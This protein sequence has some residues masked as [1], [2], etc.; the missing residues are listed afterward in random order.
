MHTVSAEA[1]DGIG[2]PGARVRDRYGLSNM[3]AKPVEPTLQPRTN[4]SYIRLSGLGWSSV[5]EYI[6]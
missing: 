2:C 3:G 5:V 1:R 6:H 4:H